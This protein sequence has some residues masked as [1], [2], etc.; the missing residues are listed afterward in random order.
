MVWNN[1][2]DIREWFAADSA[3]VFLLDD[4]RFQQLL[5]FRR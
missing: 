3:P 5:H 2:V 1:I 4:F